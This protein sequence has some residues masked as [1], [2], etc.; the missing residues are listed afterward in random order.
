VELVR[1]PVAARRRPERR[2]RL[3]DLLADA[4]FLLRADQLGDARRRQHRP[5]ELVVV[6]VL[7]GPGDVEG[8]ARRETGRGRHLLEDA[9]GEKV[10]LRRRVRGPRRKERPDH[11]LHRLQVAPLVPSPH[12]DHD[13]RAGPC[14]APGLAERGDHVHRE[15][16]RVEA[17][18]HVEEVVLVR[19]RLEVADPQLGL[20]HVR[21][22]QLEQR[23]RRVDPVDLSSPLGREPEEHPGAAAHLQH[24]LTRREPHAAN[25]L[26]VGGHLLLLGRSPVRGPGSPEPAPLL[27]SLRDRCGRLHVR[28]LARL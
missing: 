23:L 1:E 7:V 25:R 20:G 18:D 3:D 15:E 28:L 27:R 6:C 4:L 22:G 2:E 16:E 14:D 19:Q 21:T 13:R 17:G 8:L 5:A 9:G 26:L 10:G 12:L 11:G 24:P